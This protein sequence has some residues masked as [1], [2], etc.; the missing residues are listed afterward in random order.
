[1]S[2]F[3]YGFLVLDSGRE[4]CGLLRPIGGEL[5]SSG[6]TPPVVDKGWPA[7]PID[8]SPIVFRLTHQVRVTLAARSPMHL[9]SSIE[10]RLRLSLFPSA[11]Y[12]SATYTAVIRLLTTLCAGAPSLIMPLHQDGIA[13]LLK[14]VLDGNGSPSEGS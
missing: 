13:V 11:V 6:G 10:H 12:S 8:S 1:M 7:S 4:K 3:V 9:P 2:V 14:G 5:L